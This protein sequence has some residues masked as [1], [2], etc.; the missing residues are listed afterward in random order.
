MG[1]RA[2][3]LKAEKSVE[4]VMKHLGVSDAAVYCWENGDTLPRSD[5]LLK[6]AEFYGCTADALLTDNPTKKRV[7]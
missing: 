1:F 5:K 7:Q 6:L 2:E 4:D 3:R